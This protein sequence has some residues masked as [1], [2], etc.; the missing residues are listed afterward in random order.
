MNPKCLLMSGWTDLMS[1]SSPLNVFT[2]ITAAVSPQS[3]GTEQALGAAQVTPSPWC[4]NQYGSKKNGIFSLSLAAIHFGCTFIIVSILAVLRD[5]PPS[6]SCRL[7]TEGTLLPVS[8]HT[9]HT[10]RTY[11]IMPWFLYPD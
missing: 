1:C 4:L 3:S 6:Y 2:I 9:Y 11:R 5:C 10:H 7:R 8:W